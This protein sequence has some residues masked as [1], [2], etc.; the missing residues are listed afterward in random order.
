MMNAESTGRLYQAMRE[1][2]ALPASRPKA[3]LSE[4][5]KAEIR[6][7]KSDDR[8]RRTEGG[9]SNIQHPTSNLECG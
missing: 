8:A 7:L 1:N 3:T 5:Q 2:H 6:K 9:T 4:K